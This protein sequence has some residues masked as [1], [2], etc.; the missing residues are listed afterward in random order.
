LFDSEQ[1]KIPLFYG[2]V[3]PSKALNSIFYI[4]NFEILQKKC[5]MFSSR[6]LTFGGALQTSM[7]LSWFITAFC[8]LSPRLEQI[9]Q[10]AAVNQQEAMIKTQNPQAYMQTVKS[11]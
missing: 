8:S 10:P 3:V 2:K 5:I 11:L 7:S 4:Q 6:I 9:S 1:W